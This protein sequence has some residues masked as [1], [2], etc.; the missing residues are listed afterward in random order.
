MVIPGINALISI[1]AVAV[2]AV[3]KPAIII[4]VRT[5]LCND[6]DALSDQ[7]NSARCLSG[8][9]NYSTNCQS[10][11][12]LCRNRFRIPWRS[13]TKAKTP[14]SRFPARL[15]RER[16]DGPYRKRFPDARVC[17]FVQCDEYDTATYQRTVAIRQEAR[18]REKGYLREKVCTI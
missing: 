4:C 12:S 10:D 15:C 11:V 1:A 5:G 6:A 2:Y 14:S 8:G 3:T 13:V 18:R 9:R 7:G 16:N 17:R